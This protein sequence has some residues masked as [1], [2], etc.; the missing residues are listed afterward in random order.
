VKK[1]LKV[2]LGQR[3]RL[4]DLRAQTRFF[5]ALTQRTGNAL[6]MVPGSGHV[7][8]PRAAVA[9]IQDGLTAWLSTHG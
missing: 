3:D 2:W 6:S 4:V 8:L 7:M 5:G 1:P 9:S